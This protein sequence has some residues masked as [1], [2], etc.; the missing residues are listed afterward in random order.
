MYNFIKNMNPVL[1]F[2]IFPSEIFFFFFVEGRVEATSK[3]WEQT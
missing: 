3:C 2:I 1:H